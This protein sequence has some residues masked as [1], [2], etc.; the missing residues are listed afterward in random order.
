MKPKSPARVAAGHANGL[1]SAGTKTPE[2]KAISARN[3]ITHGFSSDTVLLSF[4][5]PAAYQQLRN[6]YRDLYKPTNPVE[7]QMIDDIVMAKWRHF[8]LA[9]I[10]KT[11]FEMESQAVEKDV[12]TRFFEPNIHIRLATAYRSAE[13]TD[14]LFST[15]NRHS[16]RLAREYRQALRIFKEERANPGAPP[17]SIENKNKQNEGNDPTHLASESEIRVHLCSSAAKSQ[18]TPPENKNTQNEGNDPS[19]EMKPLQSKSVIC[20]D[21][22]PF[23]A[24]NHVAPVTKPS[25]AANALPQTLS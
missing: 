25:S 21:R 16:S 24:Q 1:K 8:R 3:A 6:D 4:E 23:A 18:A 10:E 20:V 13:D 14:R 7:E 22:R 19:A 11:T 12:N 2:G 9:N 17:A 5:D 15:L